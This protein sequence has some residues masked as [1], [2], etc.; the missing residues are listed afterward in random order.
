MGRFTSPDPSGLE[1][2]PYLYAQGDPVNL[3]DPS[4]LAACDNSVL[5]A[6]PG[7][8]VCAD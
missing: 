1:V 7:A 3:I 2:N 4:G 5:K 8:G 6:A